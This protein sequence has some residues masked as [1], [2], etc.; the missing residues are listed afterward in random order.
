MRQPPRFTGLAIAAAALIGCADHPYDPNAPAVDP[1]APRVHIT[2]PARGAF[3]GDL[4]TLVVTGTAT[5]D[6]AVTAVRV[7]GVAATLDGAGGWSATVPVGA[8]TQLLHAEA[9]D[10]QGNV[11]KES[12]AVVVG[13]VRPIAGAVPRAITA[14]ISAPTFTAVGRAVTGLLRTG[15]L[16]SLVA[17]INPV[18][19]LGSGG[20][21][22]R[23]SISALTMGSATSVTLTAARGGLT[24]D[25]ELDHVSVTLHLAYA[26]LGVGGSSDVTV[27][28]SHVKIAGLLAVGIAKGA[29]DL[30]LASPDVA[31]TGFA[32]T[33]TG[34]PGEILSLLHLET[35]IGPILGFVTQQLIAP[36]LDTALAGLVA[37]RTIDVLG[38]QVDLQLAPARV[39][40]DPTG[41]IIE[42]DT[43]LRA[44]GDAAS[45]GFVYVA[46][47][48]PAMATT[49]WQLAVAD[50]AAN[51][52]LASL[53]T[54][55]GLDAAL[56]LTT[57]SYGTLGQLYDRVEL[58][59]AVPPYVDARGAALKLT[60]GDLVATFKHGAEVA[61]RIAISAELD[62]RVVAGA[63]GAPRLDVGSPT[64]YVD[65]LDE[66]VDGA[67]ALSNA[68]FELITSF[69]LARV[70]AV[71][72]GSLGAVPLPSVGGVGVHDLAIAPQAG[73]LVIDGSLN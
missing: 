64:T 52:L 47:Q 63:G 6:R 36:L 55:K 38:T 26:V 3:A 40:F 43:T 69:A 48:A 62:V 61:T 45:P 5:D 8:G 10:A 15:D 18:L 51:Q 44:H 49:G 34:V 2:S 70:I 37:T 46:G 67:N 19:D 13:P 33:A 60:L 31:V 30:R 56:D 23:A 17:P 12:R 27:S 16:A 9:E 72:S 71:A 14:A 7:N 25:A 32:L 29:F 58:A 41:A 1:A 57:G 11:G 39:N 21:Y 73:Y 54:A 35:A 20:T 68:Q 22:A 4:T 42:V 53:W 66:H 28:A 50:G 24:V 59:T 65:V